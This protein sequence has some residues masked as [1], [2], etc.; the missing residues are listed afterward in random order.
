VR[1]AFDVAKF[2]EAFRQQAKRPTA[3]A[4]WR[5][6]T[7]QGDQMGFLFTIQH[8]RPAWDRASDEDPLD[9]PFDEGLA[10]AVDSNRSDVQGL[11]DLQVR[12]RRTEGTTVGLQQDACSRQFA[13]GGLPFGDERFQPFAFFHR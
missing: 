11:A 4:R 6:T 7:G 8:S 9:P 13:S 1:D 5:M 10:D 2:D 3:P 12:P